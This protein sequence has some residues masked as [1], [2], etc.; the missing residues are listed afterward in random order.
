[1]LL[2]ERWSLIL[3]TAPYSEILDR[4]TKLYISPGSSMLF[5]LFIPVMCFKRTV[6]ETG[7]FVSYK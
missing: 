6:E 5:D 7:A 3:E 2:A 1:M 4:K